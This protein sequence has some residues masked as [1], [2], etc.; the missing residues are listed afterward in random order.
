MAHAAKIL[1][2]IICTRIE[3]IVEKK[4]SDDQFGFRRNKGT[5]EAI[6]SLRINRKT[7]RI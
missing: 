3:N 1:V 4:L 7:N 5:R 6:L 2:K